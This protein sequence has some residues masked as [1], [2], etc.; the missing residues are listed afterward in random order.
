VNIL[1]AALKQ[2]WDTSQT[3]AD[4]DLAAQQGQQDLDADGVSDETEAW[5]G[6]SN[7]TDETGPEGLTDA[8]YTA[9]VDRVQKALE[10]DQLFQK[11]SD[12]EDEKTDATSV[13][14]RGPRTFEGSPIAIRCFDLSG[15]DPDA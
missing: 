14:E 6:T 12:E 9:S 7:L 10:G 1:D 3:G 15:E 2:R 5:L 4:A 11:F 8:G 13:L